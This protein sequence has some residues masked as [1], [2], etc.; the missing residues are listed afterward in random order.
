L[1]P[2][3]ALTVYSL[4]LVLFAIKQLGASPITMATG[5]LAASFVALLLAPLSY[6]PLSTDAALVLAAGMTSMV[7]VGL[8]P[9]RTGASHPPLQAKNR[10]SAA[11]ISSHANKSARGGLLLLIVLILVVLTAVLLGYRAFVSGISEATNATFS[12]LTLEEVRRAQNTGARGGGA[13]A[14]LGSL[15]PLLGCL[16]LYGAARHSRVFLIGPLVA[17]AIA[18]QNP[19][20]L[21]SI[22]LLVTLVAFWLY[23]RAGQGKVAHELPFPDR[24]RTQPGSSSRPSVGRAKI[25]GRSSPGWSRRKAILVGILAAGGALTL[26]NVVGN[27]LGKS[28]STAAGFPAYDWPAWTLSPVFYFTGSY[29]ALTVA[30]SNDTSPYEPGTSFFSVLRLAAVFDP[31]IRPPETI[32]QYS[33]IPV[34]FNL[35]SGFGQVYFDVGF[36]GLVVVFGGLGMLLQRLH[37]AALRGHLPSIWAVST[38]TSVVLAL[39]Q[40]FVLFNLDVTVRLLVGVGMFVA[41]GRNRRGRES[42]RLGQVPTRLRGL[43]A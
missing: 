14:L 32:A 23:L 24:P 33:S 20:R 30:M 7:A 2:T 13:L 1:I 39:P 12:Q 31:S 28:A 19:S 3:I 10:P 9:R 11:V 29:P 18:L 27:A 21:N 35:Y 40:G 5:V 26:F 6:Y 25:G 37:V 42:P 41:L 34:P 36:L 4:L 38:L 8:A 43:P 16:G 22:S 17:L 15:G